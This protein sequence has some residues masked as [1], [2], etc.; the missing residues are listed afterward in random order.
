MRN[1]L[2]VLPLLTLLSP[3]VLAQ[4]DITCDSLQRKSMAK[5]SQDYIYAKTFPMMKRGGEPTSSALVMSEGSV[6]TVKFS[7][8]GGDESIILNLINNGNIIAS[9][10]NRITLRYFDGFTIKCE[11]T[12]MY[13]FNYEVR[14][15]SKDKKQGVCGYISVGFKRSN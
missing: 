3:I 14:E 9:S 1:I 13:Y 2:F 10:F 11:K 12:G 7:V 15:G 4:S 8:V 6:Y 5:I